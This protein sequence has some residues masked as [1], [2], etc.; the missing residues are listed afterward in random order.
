MMKDTTEARTQ[1]TSPSPGIATAFVGA[2]PWA[3]NRMQSY[4]TSLRYWFLIALAIIATATTGPF[5]TRVGT[6]FPVR[7]LFWTMVLTPAIV[8]QFALSILLRE[9]ARRI[10]LAW[11]WPALI[12]GVVGSVPILGCV[13]IANA[14]LGAAGPIL[15]LHD[16][17]APTVALTILLTMGLN[18]LLPVPQ[19]LWGM[20]RAS[21]PERD[22]AE[23]DEDAG[24]LFGRLPVELGREVIWARADN[25]HTEVCTS[26]GR[27][28][29]LIR[30]SDA[31][32]ELAALPGFRVHRS[33][34]ANLAEATHFDTSERSG[35]TLLM[36]DGTRVPV[37]RK[38]RARVA[39]ALQER[40]AQSEPEP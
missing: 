39:D 12:A 2:I 28:R 18:A 16:T 29:V 6:P 8:G 9:T 5:E 38:N 17:L 32:A 3:R 34:W 21:S 4:L 25:H 36:I 14:L 10:G 7:I 33:W 11:G 30:L 37:S 35:L 20:P 26:L 15:S 1:A 22:A 24:P 19:R 40:R 13:M 31:E 27:T 23:R